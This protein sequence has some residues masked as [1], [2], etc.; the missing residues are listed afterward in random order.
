MWRDLH[1]S[2]IAE[3]DVVRDA[4]SNR[5]LVH[6]PEVVDPPDISIDQVAMRVE[7]ISK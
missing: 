3:H 4:R 6:H 2:S 7:G 5:L 1:A